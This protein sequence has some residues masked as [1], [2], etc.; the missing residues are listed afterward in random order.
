VVLVREQM[1]CEV[2]FGRG[3][4]EEGNKRGRSRKKSSAKFCVGCVAPCV[5][6]GER[7]LVARE[8]NPTA[9][10]FCQELRG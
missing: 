8:E 2:L 6:G 4:R 7:P 5:G 10:L 9:V 3:L 1:L